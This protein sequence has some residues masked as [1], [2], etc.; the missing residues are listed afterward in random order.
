MTRQNQ[1]DWPNNFRV[2]RL[3]PAVEYINANRQ[4]YLLMQ[5]VN[6]IVEQYDAIICPNNWGNQSAITNLTG[7]PAICFPIGYN[8][9]QLPR[10]ITLIGKLYDEASIITVAKAYQNATQWNKEHPALFK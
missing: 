1:F 9:Q 7:H 2:S 5:A 3:I 4:R 10:S 8:A 6:K